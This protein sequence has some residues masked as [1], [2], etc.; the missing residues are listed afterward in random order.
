MG[1]EGMSAF[2]FGRKTG[3]SQL[4][5]SKS[6]NMRLSRTLGAVGI[7]CL[8]AAV[9]GLVLTDVAFVN[10]PVV[11]AL[12]DGGLPTSGVVVS[13]EPTIALSV[14]PV[15]NAD[16]QD[17]H[18]VANLVTPSGGGVAIAGH[19]VKVQTPY[20]L[21]YTATIQMAGDNNNLVSTANDDLE[22]TSTAGSLENPAQLQPNE[23]GVA[24]RAR[25]FG[26]NPPDGNS[27]DEPNYWDVNYHLNLYKCDYSDYFSTD[28]NIM[29]STE[30][31]AVPSESSGAAWQILPNN[32][33]SVDGYQ[34]K[35]RME[36]YYG[37][38]VSDSTIAGEYVGEVVY[39]ATMNP[40]APAVLSSVSP[41][42]YQIGSD[43]SSKIQLTGENLL[44]AYQVFI[45]FNGNGQLDE[46]IAI[47]GGSNIVSELCNNLNVPTGRGVYCNI[48]TDEAI[49]ELLISDDGQK[50]NSKTFKIYVVTLAGI[51]EQPL[52]FTYYRA[53][54]SVE[55]DDPGNDDGITVDYDNGLIPVR[56]QDGQW[57]VVTDAELEASTDNW[58][59]YNTD[60]RWANAVTVKADKLA[61]Y[62]AATGKDETTV[63]NN[64]D[65]LGY[66]V[67]IPRYA[68]EVQRRDATDR[69]VTAGNYDIRFE[70]GNDLVKTPAKCVQNTAEKL[71]QNINSAVDYRNNCGLNR[72]YPGNNKELAEGG[73]TW[74]THPAFIWG[75][76]V[77]NGIWVG[78]FETTGSIVSPT[79]KPSE[80]SNIEQT[81][82][83]FYTA[84]KHIGVYDSD[85][86]GGSNV[87]SGENELNATGSWS[88]LH[89][90]GSSSSH[91]LKNSE[92][93]A[94]VYLSASGYGAGIG[95][96]RGNA[97]N[98]AGGSTDA[99]GNNSVGGGVTGCGQASTS[100]AKF[101]NGKTSNVDGA[102]GD[103]SNAYNGTNGKQASTTGNEYGV[104]D[105]AGGNYEYV[106]ANL[107]NLAETSESNGGIGQ[108]LSGPY[109]DL[110]STADGFTNR[111]D[112]GR[113][114]I[115]WSQVNGN[116]R[117][118][119]WNNDVCTWST[120]GGQALHETKVVQSVDR[121][122]Q[123]WLG[124]GPHF[125]CS[126]GTWF[127]RGGYAGEVG[128][129]G[130]AGVFSSFGRPSS[131]AD[132]NITYRVSL[133][134]LND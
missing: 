106:A 56:Y 132:V 116:W 81:V 85:N 98:P 10:N 51:V 43:D 35:D 118:F 44:T 79:V 29:L 95:N 100:G 73:A 41:S 92:W 47:G 9:I 77:L 74:A 42:S 1:S 83:E 108:A 55:P 133:M 33:A 105:M 129:N 48:P 124:N 67:Y 45:D 68:Y 40:V 97:V 72:N 127:T 49:Q 87:S 21:G 54:P 62:V 94:V 121:Y 2:S 3:C 25:A 46:S 86:T 63:I 78:K 96:I 32:E 15:F 34:D 11:R 17:G 18:P 114:P 99:D 36:V 119:Y 20:N 102:C 113:S 65:V 101:D 104:Y 12:E 89:N 110:Y 69:W 5:I 4:S 19:A 53:D 22:I 16:V 7:I 24:I 14:E 76:R 80:L 107:S 117:E 30:Y 128:E 37:V 13:A 60:R 93:G 38:R 120:C 131:G 82:G 115:A 122:G 27:C 90:L 109:V 61:D 59:N 126:D 66:W 134:R 28:Q 91:M 58:F 112:S 52:D 88:S 39:T 75:D 31:A 84:A 130:G 64:D 70:T 125:V 57:V 8:V 23:W 6:L 123:A 26:K 103:S 111:G 71:E 50:V